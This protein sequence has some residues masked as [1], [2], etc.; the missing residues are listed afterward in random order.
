MWG[1]RGQGGGVV[2][3]ENRKIGKPPT[4]KARLN[5]IMG[6]SPAVPDC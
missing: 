2:Q 6:D 4:L 5:C 1:D 3:E